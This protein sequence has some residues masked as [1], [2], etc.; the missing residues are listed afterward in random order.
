[1]NHLNGA[2]IN[3]LGALLGSFVGLLWGGR[4]NPL[5][6]QQAM[7]VMGLVVVVIGIKMAIPL[8]DPV[9]ALLSVVVGA[10]FGSL[11]KIGDRLDAFGHRVE[12]LVGKNGFMQGFISAALIFNV[13]AMAIVGSLQAGLTCRPTILETKAILDG[14]TALL[15][16][17][18]AGWGVMLA[19]P[20]TFMYEGILSILASLLQHF[21]SGPI[22][23]DLTVVGGI[24][25]TAIGVNFVSEKSLINIAD[26]LP[27]LVLTV[28]LGWLKAKGLAFV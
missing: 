19:A 2:V 16:A 22:L 11:L 15:L 9:N 13:G 21:L 27:A 18:T 6:R 1:M 25:I 26:L 12:R 14:V 23:T 5:F 10:W 7:R 8:S 20:L 4:L 24:M 17:S 3:G 28:I